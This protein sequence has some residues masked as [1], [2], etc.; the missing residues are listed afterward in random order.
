MKSQIQ[1]DASNR[2]VLSRD[3]RRAAGIPPRQK[4]RIIAS[5]G[6]IVLE[7]E[8]ELTGRIVRRGKLRVWTGKVPQTSLSDAVSA[9]RRYER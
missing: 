9:T 5:P 7:V 2:I 6:R 4:L 8:P 3:V 1:L